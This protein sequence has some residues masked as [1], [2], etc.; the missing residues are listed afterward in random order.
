[1]KRLLFL[2]RRLQVRLKNGS[3]VFQIGTFD[4]DTLGLSVDVNVS[5]FAAFSHS[6]VSDLFGLHVAPGCNLDEGHWCVV[7]TL[8]SPAA[9]VGT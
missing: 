6:N 3:E 8:F 5:R 1:M 9:V 2:P 4:V 7:Y